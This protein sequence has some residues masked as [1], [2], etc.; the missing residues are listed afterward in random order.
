MIYIYTKI[1]FRYLY[2]MWNVNTLLK[3]GFKKR[4]SSLDID[5]IKKDTDTLFILGSGASI[6]TINGK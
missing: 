5:E 1:L 2:S 4:L 3:L 6:N